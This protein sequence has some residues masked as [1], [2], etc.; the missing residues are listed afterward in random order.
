MKKITYLSFF[1]FILFVLVFNTSLSA[2]QVKPV[3]DFIKD[4]GTN[5]ISATFRI[6]D[7][8]ITDETNANEDDWLES[9]NL[10][11]DPDVSSG[12]HEVYAK[13]YVKDHLDSDNLYRLFITTPSYTITGT[14]ADDRVIK[15]TSITGYA[16]S[17]DFKI[18]LYEVGS[19]GIKA[20]LDADNDSDLS[21]IFLQPTLSY[22][23][24]RIWSILRTDE[25][26]AD[27]NGNLE[28]FK[29]HFN[30]DV[31]G[32]GED[33]HTREVYAKL[34]SKISGYSDEYYQLLTTTSTFTITGTYEDD[35]VIDVIASNDLPNNY[36]FQ[37]ELYDVESGII[38]VINNDINYPVLGNIPLQ[39]LLP[40]LNPFLI[41]PG[42]GSSLVATIKQ[43]THVMPG[44]PLWEG[45]N[46]ID[47][48]FVNKYAD[49]QEGTNFVVSLYL[50]N[51]LIHSETFSGLCKDCF[52]TFEDIP[53]SVTAGYHSLKVVLDETNVV[54]ESNEDS[55]D[56]INYQYWYWEPQPD[57]NVTP[58]SLTIDQGG[59][60]SPGY[61][62]IEN[63]G[64]GALTI[65]IISDNKNW[66]YTSGYPST[67]FNIE[68]GE[69]QSI[70][71][72]V[73]WPKLSSTQ[74]T[75]TVTITSYDPDEPVITVDVTAIPTPPTI[76]SITPDKAS[77]GTGAQV[78]ITGDNF[79]DT[80]GTGKVEFDCRRVFDAAYPAVKL[81]APIISWSNTQIICTVPI[82]IAYGYFLVSANSGPVTVT[83]SFNETS[84]GFPF[85]VTFGWAGYKW[86]GN[87]VGYKIKITSDIL[88]IDNPDGFETAIQNAAKTWNEV[89]ANFIFQYEGTE[90]SESKIGNGVNEIYLGGLPYPE[91]RSE[92]YVLSDGTSIIECDIVINRDHHYSTDGT[93][94]SDELDLQSTALHGFG[95]SLSLMKLYGYTG[96]GEY[97]NGKIMYASIPKGVL[98]RTL[99]PDDIAGIMYLY[100]PV[101]G[102]IS[103]TDNTIPNPVP[104]AGGNYSF[105][106]NLSGNAGSTWSITKNPESASWLTVSPVTGGI[107]SGQN[108]DV[109]VTANPDYTARACTLTVASPGAT[110]SPINIVVNQSGAVIPLNILEL[111]S[112]VNGQEFELEIQIGDVNNLKVISFDLVYPTQYIN[113]AGYTNGSILP[114]ATVIPDDPQGKVSASVYS[115]SSGYTGSGT[116]IKLKFIVVNNPAIGTPINFAFQNPLANDVNGNLIGLAYETK[117]ITI[118]SGLTVWPGDTDNNSTV[119][120]VDINPIIVNFS[121]T[122][123]KRNPGGLFWMGQ[124]GAPWSPE[125][126]TYADCNGNGTIEITDINGVI[127]NFNKTH[128]TLA[129]SLDIPSAVLNNPG[130]KASYS[131]SQTGGA[132][133]WVYID[134]GSESNIVTDVNVV[135]FE[136]KY[137][138]TEY[139]DYSSYEIGSFFNGSTAI[140]IPEDPIGKVSVCAYNLTQGY[141]GYGEVF[142][143]KYKVQDTVETYHPVNFYWGLV[144]ANDIGGTELTLDTV[145]FN[146]DV[147]PVELITFNGSVVNNRVELQ[148][149][150]ATETNN[151]GFEIERA[152]NDKNWKRVGFVSGRGTTT[153]RQNYSFTDNDLSVS[154][155]YTYRLKQ[156]DYDGSFEYSNEIVLDVDLIPVEY[157]LY[158]NYPNPFNPTTKIRYGIPAESYVSLVVYNLLGDK[159]EILVDEKKPA[160]SY[161]VEFNANSLP[162]GVYFYSLQTEGFK[163]TKKLILL[164]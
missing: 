56:N 48:A 148:W 42:W 82:D 103:V 77:A 59:N 154:G 164:R 133:F 155:S 2:Q 132:E 100:P 161:E 67:P 39:K 65:S 142:R 55:L 140:V 44:G 98:K 146:A 78:T 89:G 91:I 61:F 63:V 19:P 87:V 158:Q 43:G 162:S 34:Y 35:I 14:N 143:L 157:T 105:K 118:Q 93:P 80:Q 114:N 31:S 75:G 36:S 124:M 74:E 12:T 40:N 90:T 46:Y 127:V 94:S 66:L 113:Y 92:A 108:V 15:I 72:S 121:S 24:Y 21:N 52:G 4:T 109:S 18:E 151:K 58:I 131:N 137:T 138:G 149:S 71:V 128:T 70:T 83:N 45:T 3:K 86:A 51:N 141:T 95:N 159:I 54:E 111:S 153:E 20:V 147:I 125:N 79:G 106:I 136:L 28:S 119:S 129:K 32:P 41:P 33:P 99:H 122:G 126:R 11:Y 102:N 69:S 117:T 156:I 6:Y 107:G 163:S 81:T 104:A 9:F 116:V 38:R 64:T 115:T 49:I 30:P 47:V 5:G 112:A 57:I 23:H 27:G 7:A 22:F 60:G 85:K 62:T 123:P 50:D 96:D 26:D 76:T 134:I 139:I 8:W 73:D 25:V 16:Y 145:G 88:K 68:P 110:G 120:I 10:H 150:A 160:G 29:L 144:S 37:I 135:S 1:S 13:L 17:F 84:N 152:V 130:L 53:V 101:E 97:D